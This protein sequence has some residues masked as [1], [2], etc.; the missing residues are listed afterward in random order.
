MDHRDKENRSYVSSKACRRVRSQLNHALDEAAYALACDTEA[1][2][3]YELSRGG[4]SRRVWRTKVWCT[5]FLG[6]LAIS[7]AS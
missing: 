3:H 6:A 7:F 2:I 1:S 4:L 5:A